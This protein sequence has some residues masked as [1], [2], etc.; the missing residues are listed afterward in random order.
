MKK[1]NR[2]QYLKLW[3]KYLQGKNELD[4]R[5]LAAILEKKLTG[6]YSP[7]TLKR[8][9]AN[10][11]G[12]LYANGYLTGKKGKTFTGVPLPI[13]KEITRPVLERCLRSDFS[14]VTLEDAEGKTP[15]VKEKPAAPTRKRSARRPVPR[16]KSSTVTVPA[17]KSSS[18]K[19]ASLKGDKAPGLVGRKSDLLRM[20]QGS[21]LYAQQLT[22]QIEDLESQLAGY[23]RIFEVL[24]QLFT[25]EMDDLEDWLLRLL[26]S[27]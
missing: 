11:I 24:Q 8:Y 9:Q 6:L 13:V 17:G 2:S 16:K 23:Q 3:L 18:R 27:S 14:K 5:A 7:P 12:N 20:G 19:A 22:Q 26:P 10:L 21:F 25:R 4:P 1:D 15:A